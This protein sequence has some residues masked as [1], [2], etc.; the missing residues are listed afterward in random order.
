M[1]P[2]DE[3]AKFSVIWQTFVAL[4]VAIVTTLVVS[5]VVNILIIYLNTLL[6]DESAGL[7][8]LS[9]AITSTVAGVYA[10]RAACDKLFS[11]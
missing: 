3:A 4:L 9:A 8:A 7:I 6:S 1:K 11:H 10:A 2:D 5:T